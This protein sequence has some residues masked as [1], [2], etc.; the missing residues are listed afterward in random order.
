MPRTNQRSLPSLL[1]VIVTL[2]SCAIA[3]PRLTVRSTAFTVFPRFM[4]DLYA[5]MDIHYQYSSTPSFHSSYFITRCLAATPSRSP[6]VE[7]LTF[8]R[9]S[10]RSWHPENIVPQDSL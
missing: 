1:Q 8:P 6:S 5:V 7:S 4:N 9:Q 2:C 3:P 10:R